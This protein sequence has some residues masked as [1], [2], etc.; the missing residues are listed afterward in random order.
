MLM[1][2][3]ADQL[4]K[5]NSKRLGG[6]FSDK[7]KGMIDNPCDYKL[8]SNPSL[9]DIMSAIHEEKGS[10]LP[11]QS[12]RVDNRA[13]TRCFVPKSKESKTCTRSFSEGQA[14][15]VVQ[16]VQATAIGNPCNLPKGAAVRSLEDKSGSRGA[17]LMRL[18]DEKL[19]ADC[20]SSEVSVPIQ[21]VQGTASPPRTNGQPALNSSAE[22]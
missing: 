18:Q 21:A 22:K 13:W 4:A 15:E 19:A 2:S 14:A 20:G 3:Q 16:P 10:T 9:Y 11:S 5:Q 6:D 17:V 8:P 12:E 1:A 7:L